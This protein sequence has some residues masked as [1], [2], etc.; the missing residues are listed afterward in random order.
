CF[1]MPAFSDDHT[2]LKSGELYFSVK[3]ASGKL[4]TRKKGS[5]AIASH[6]LVTDK[7]TGEVCGYA[8]FE[9]EIRRDTKIPSLEILEHYNDKFKST[10]AGL[11][12]QWEKAKDDV[13]VNQKKIRQAAS[14]NDI[15]VVKSAVVTVYDENKTGHGT[16]F[17]IS[18][19]GYILTNAHVVAHTGDSPKVKLYDGAEKTAVLIK[20]DAVRDLALI[21]IE[22][23]NYT[24][25]KMG[26]SDKIN[27]ND[28]VVAIGTPLLMSNEGR[29][30]KGLAKGSFDVSGKGRGQSFIIS[31]ILMAPGN[32]GGP[33]LNEKMEVVGVNTLSNFIYLLRYF[34]QTGVFSAE[35]LRGLSSPINETKHFIEK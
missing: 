10:N 31:N 15:E 24:Y 16:G 4:I 3:D 21:K 9:Y 32:S 34:I 18:R 33:L 1:A 17:F 11:K 5:S 23:K 8:E 20:V 2:Y 25:L 30:A 27:F 28:E 29:V 26:D 13:S 14:S 35:Y 22:G 6:A 19:N 12:P 7:K